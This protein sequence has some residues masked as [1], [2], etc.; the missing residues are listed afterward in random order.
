VIISVF[1]RR[2]RAGKTFDD[3]LEAWAAE[4]GFDIPTRVINA[5][6]LQD[7]RDIITIGFVA[8]DADE[9]AA[10]LSGDHPSETARHDRIAEVIESTA[11]RGQ[12]DVRTEHDLT[13]DPRPIPI[14]S[15]ESLF[16]AF[17]GDGG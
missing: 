6:S 17:L 12:Y 8:A 5:P 2:L 4:T 9:L 3:F 10:F 1:V 13:A 11:L 7:P 14:G 16:A 15:P